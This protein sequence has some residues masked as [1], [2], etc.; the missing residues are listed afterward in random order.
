MAEDFIIWD[1]T[2]ALLSGTESDRTVVADI[3]R[4]DIK[5][6]GAIIG[7]V[8]GKKGLSREK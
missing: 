7:V 3:N 5:P 2:A 1:K 4:I 8:E 6:N